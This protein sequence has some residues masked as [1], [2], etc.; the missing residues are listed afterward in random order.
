MPTLY[1]TLHALYELQ[2]LDTQ[3]AR[4]RRAEAAL[5]TG[6]Q[7]GQAAAAARAEA[8]AQNAAFH[9][10]QGDL[11]DS[12]LKLK[13]VEDKRKTYHDRLYQGSITN[14]KELGNIEKEIAA[15]GRQRSDLDERILEL[16]E[17]V[18]TAQTALRAAEQTAHEA[19]T[20]HGDT[21]TTFRSRH[22]ALELEATDLTRRRGE[23]ATLIQDKTLLKRYED[24][25]AKSGGL[26]I[27]KIEEAN[28]GACHMSLPS[29]VIKEV[30][31]YAAPQRCENC[32]RLLL[33]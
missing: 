33:T 17:Q 16:M 6:T 2:Q 3:L 5:D 14:A 13:S 9:R 23:A 7:A 10:L 12:E 19:D 1:E 11:K 18:E 31:E 26:A 29:T 15:L 30:K 32:G 22:A 20:R 27:A 25:R 28:C 8:D 24:I 21:V 4:T